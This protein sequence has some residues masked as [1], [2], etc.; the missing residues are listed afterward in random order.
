M[1]RAL[2]RKMAEAETY[3]EWKEAAIAYDERTG[4]ERWKQGEKLSLI[5][6]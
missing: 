5:H 3:E 4:L 1:S 2:E 6:I